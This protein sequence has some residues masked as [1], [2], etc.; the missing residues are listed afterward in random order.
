LGKG[1]GALGGGGEETVD[2]FVALCISSG[3]ICIFLGEIGKSGK[4]IPLSLFDLYISSGDLCILLKETLTG[5]A[6][7]SAGNTGQSLPAEA[8]SA[9]GEGRFCCA[10]PAVLT[11]GPWPHKR[12][13]S[14]HPLKKV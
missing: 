4:E 11:A 9:T 8:G 7:K 14:S 3:E 12:G 6:V 13:I 2:S 1:F 5:P 10:L